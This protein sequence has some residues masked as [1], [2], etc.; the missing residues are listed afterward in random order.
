MQP[1]IDFSQQEAAGLDMFVGSGLD[2]LSEVAMDDLDMGNFG[3]DVSP[4]G[5]TPE[6]FANYAPMAA[7]L[8]PPGA[9]VPFNTMPYY[10][11][12]NVLPHQGTGNGF[13]QG[14]FQTGMLNNYTLSEHKA[15]LE[16]LLVW[17]YGGHGTSGPDQTCAKLQDNFLTACCRPLPAIAQ[18]SLV[19]NQATV[20]N[21]GRHR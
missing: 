12:A 4:L 9:G 6:T 14:P 1:G 11:Q 18:V 7:S 13:Q 8:G 10:S 15:L 19:D 2:F 3:A 16:G 21:W 20:E 5:L 17:D